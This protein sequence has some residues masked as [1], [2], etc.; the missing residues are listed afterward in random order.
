MPPKKSTQQN[1]GAAGDEGG[2]P[3][4][5]P[6]YK[7]LD[8]LLK[9]AAKPQNINW[10]AVATAAHFANAKSAKDRFRQVCKKYNWFEDT[11]AATAQDAA[12]AD[13]TPKKTPAKRARKATKPTSED[14]AALGDDEAESPVKKRKISPKKTAPKEGKQPDAKTEMEQ[15]NEQKE[16]TANGT[17]ADADIDAEN[18]D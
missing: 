6:E 17:A 2:V 5:T 3:L 9:H 13:A 18:K 8:A 14:S 12:A 11:E 10:E 1:N 16:E 7:L 4:T 15:S